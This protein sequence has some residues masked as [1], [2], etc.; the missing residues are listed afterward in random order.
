MPRVGI[1]MGGHAVAL[2]FTH[3]VGRSR[4]QSASG[5]VSS[6]RWI[7]PVQ[8][9][10]DRRELINP[11]IAV[12]ARGAAVAVWEI[13]A[14]GSVFKEQTNTVMTTHNPAG[15]AWLLPAAVGACD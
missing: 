10:V 3:G 6:N 15:R 5:S 4:I 13:L 14:S 12:N 9:A 1:G 8:L 2:W 11:Q 7:K